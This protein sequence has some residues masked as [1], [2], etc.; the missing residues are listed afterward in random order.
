MVT[1]THTNESIAA[2]EA[3]VGSKMTDP[4]SDKEKKKIKHVKYTLA[5]SDDE[6][7]KFEAAV[8]PAVFKEKQWVDKPDETAIRK[9]KLGPK[10]E[11]D[12]L[13]Y[14]TRAG[15]KR[16]KIKHE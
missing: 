8:L 9:E 7:E 13:R 11:R 1:V 4:E 3:I 12:M 2:A 15:M 14:R 5:D 16:W 10:T 6:T